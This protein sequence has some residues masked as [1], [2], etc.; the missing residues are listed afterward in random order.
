MDDKLHPLMQGVLDTGSL[1]PYPQQFQQARQPTSPYQEPAPVYG[2]RYNSPYQKS[3]GYYGE[4]PTQYGMMT[5]WGMGGGPNQPQYPSIVP[6]MTGKELGAIRRDTEQFEKP[7]QPP[8]KPPGMLI[9]D[10]SLNR[11]QNHA[12]MRMA[13]G[14]PTFWERWTDDFHPKGEAQ[15][16]PRRSTP[17]SNGDMLSY[18]LD[19]LG[20]P[21]Q[22]VQQGS[23][24]PGM[25][26]A[27]PPAKRMFEGTATP[28]P[29]SFKPQ[30]GTPK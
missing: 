26:P 30:G 5:E 22:P 23:T 4:I 11:A 3:S 7:T 13:Q 12:D 1:G 6:G 10:V 2:Q 15:V 20:L 21:R 29:F 9:P 8:Y 27:T 24:G 28:A 25:T 14:K 16:T 19:F 18:G 17:M